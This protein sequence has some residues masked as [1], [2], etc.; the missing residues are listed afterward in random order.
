M[1]LTGYEGMTL[2]ELKSYQHG[3]TDSLYPGHPEIHHDGIEVT[4]GPLGQGIVNTVGLAIASKHLAA[5]YNR[6]GFNVVDSTIWCIA[7]DRC[8][9][10]GAAL[11]SIS[12]A[13]HWKLDNLII[14]YDNN[15]ISSNSSVELI[16]C[17]DIDLKFEACGWQTVTI[18]NTSSDVTAILGGIQGTQRHQRKPLLVNA[19]TVIGAD[20]IV[21]NTRTAHGTPLGVEEVD[22]LKKS[23]GF[24]P[25]LKFIIPDE[26]L[27][28]FSDLDPRGSSLVEEWHQI[29]NDY[30]HEYPEAGKE[31]DQRIAGHLPGAGSTHILNQCPS[32]MM[33]T[34]QSA[35]IIFQPIAER[36]NTFMVGTADLDSSVNMGWSQKTDFQNVR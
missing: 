20:S 15:R 32:S 25:A 10:E 30:A 6:P 12:L 35:G 22:R 34:V 7:G 21:I 18:K 31:L 33:S 4:T 29:F 16:S 9:Q 14:I 28:Y 8:L 1:Y 27:R 3:H 5:T 2:D 17:D 11:E 26:V 23:Y 19:R 36:T 13:G 24:D